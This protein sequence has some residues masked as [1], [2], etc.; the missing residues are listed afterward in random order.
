DG[1]IGGT[2]SKAQAAK[3]LAAAL[4]GGALAVGDEVQIP[5]SGTPVTVSSSVTVP[6]GAT[7]KVQSGA[8]LILAEDFTV[9]TG[10]TITNEAGGTIVVEEDFTV[11]AGAT[12]NNAA[13]GTVTVEGTYTLLPGVTGTNNGT[14]TIADGATVQAGAGVRIGGNG[15]NTVSAG[16]TVIVDGDTAHPFVG[17]TN[18]ALFRLTS[19]SF[20]YNNTELILAGVATLNNVNPSG[21]DMY[22][23]KGASGT[24]S[25]TINKDAELIVA[26]GAAILLGG[27]DIAANA[28]LTGDLTSLGTNPPKLTLTDNNTSGFSEGSTYLYF[29]KNDGSTAVTG[30][31]LT[32]GQ[33]KPIA[34]GT[35]TWIQNPDGGSSGDYGW[36]AD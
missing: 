7:I 5:A 8:T 26:T 35:Y 11:Q 20:T 21:D 31:G 6:A 32:P 16:G 29:F 17:T 33:T 9:S 10:A 18:A 3:N 30:S 12:I 1:V 23:K 13:T 25:L 34:S 4:G 28:P 24:Q 14:V 19:G 15:T 2:V 22:F 36:Q 27:C